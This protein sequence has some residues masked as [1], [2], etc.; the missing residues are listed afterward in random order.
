MEYWYS[1][2]YGAASHHPSLHIFFCE[3][4]HSEP[5]TSCKGINQENPIKQSEKEKHPCYFSLFFML[6]AGL[7]RVGEQTSS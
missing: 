1:T 2:G 4:K 5:A 7:T 6:A 3:L